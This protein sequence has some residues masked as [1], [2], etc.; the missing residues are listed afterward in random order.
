MSIRPATDCRDIDRAYGGDGQP[1][2]S[3]AT[4]RLNLSKEPLTEL[5][6][7]IRSASDWLASQESGAIT[8]VR[9]RLLNEYIS[10]LDEIAARM[11]RSIAERRAKAP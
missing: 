11:Q 10:T 8:A 6:P 4:A 7:R 9:R 3:R 2:S 1:A 5:M